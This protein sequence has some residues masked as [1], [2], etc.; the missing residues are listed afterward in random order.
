[1]ASLKKQVFN[2]MVWSALQRYSSILV[3]MIVTMVMAR[4]LTP[5]DF[6]VIAIAMVIIQF[7]SIFSSMGIGPAVIQRKDLTDNEIKDI[8]TFTF[9]VGIILSFILFIAS[10]SIANYYD[11]D[12]LRPVCQ[13]LCVAV[14]FNTVNMVPTALMSKNK[15]FKEMALASLYISIFSGIASI[16]SVLCGL[17]I[18][19]LLLTPLVTA[20]GMLFYNLHYYPLKLNIRFSFRPLRKIMS[21]SAY[22]FAH[23]F[24][25]F[26]SSNLDKLIIGKYISH[27]SLGYYDKAHSLVKQPMSIL[28]GVVTPIL[29]PFL[30]DFQND[31]SKIEHNHNIMVKL[32]SSFSFPMSAL[33]W[34]CGSEI[35]QIFYG[36]N[37]DMAIAT[38][39]ILVLT[40]PTNLIISTSGAYWQSTNSTKLL[41]W[42]GLLNSFII[43]AGYLITSLIFKK[44]E[45]VA[46][47]YAITC[48]IVFFITYQVMYRKVF[49]E[50][51][52]GMLKILVNPMINVIILIIVYCLSQKFLSDLNLFLSLIIKV[53]L[54][55]VITILYIQVSGRYN[56]IKMIKTKTILL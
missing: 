40:I 31:F 12:V 5:E 37:W 53:L 9:V 1:M 52:L 55:V 32:L 19:S 50:P 2:G 48:I 14:F 34:F 47:G 26:F 51:V 6:G 41:F 16:V 7:L 38:F 15:R 18:Y 33:L 28:T 49:K 13:I 44:I 30:S 3:S 42:T 20:V 35:I 10:W 24:V 17:N 45:A 11:K 21:F 27:A 29:H 43:I 4:I 46:W 56:F 39:Q 36:S 23:Q 22:Q 54:G 8:F 25:A